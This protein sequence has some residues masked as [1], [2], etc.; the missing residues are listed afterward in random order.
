M[1]KMVKKIITS[2]RAIWENYPVEIELDYELDIFDIEYTCP[3]V[4]VGEDGKR[5]VPKVVIT[6]NEAGFDST[7]VC[8]DCLKELDI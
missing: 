8:L 1:E 4:V 7:G 6:L 2:I 3:H 5:T